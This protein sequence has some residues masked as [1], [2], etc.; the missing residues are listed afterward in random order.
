MFMIVSRAPRRRLSHSES[1]FL[2]APSQFPQS[3]AGQFA[4]RLKL[5]QSA[6]FNQTVVSV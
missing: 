6:G 2:L 3:Y 4:S 1:I 5:G